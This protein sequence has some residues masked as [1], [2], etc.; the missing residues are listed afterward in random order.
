MRRVLLVVAA[1]AVGCSPAPTCSEGD[2]QCADAGAGGAAGGGSA[3]GSGGAGGMAGGTAGGM[4]GGGGTTDS[5]VTDAGSVVAMPASLSFADTGIGQSSAPLT[6]MLRNDTTLSVSFQGAQVLADAGFSVSSDGCNTSTV[7]PQ[8]AC[9]VQVVAR[10][11]VEGPSTDSLQVSVQGRPAVVVPLS[12]TGYPV[13]RLT[14]TIAGTARDAGFV[15]AADGGFSCRGGPCELVAR[16]GSTVVLEAAVPDLSL[17]FVGFDG[18]GCGTSATCQVSMS[19]DAS[20]IQADFDFY[21]RIF[22]SA[23]LRN[24]AIRDAGTCDEELAARPGHTWHFAVTPDINEAPLTSSRGWVRIDGVPFADRHSSIVDP[25]VP[26]TNYTAILYSADGGRMPEQALWAGIGVAPVNCLDFTSSSSL[27][28]SAMAFAGRERWLDFS[29]YPC[30]QLAGVACIESGGRAPLPPRPI[31]AGGRRAFRSRATGDGA[32]SNA[33]ADQ[34]CNDEATAPAGTFV[35]LRDEADGGPAINRVRLDA[36]TWYRPD[37]IPLLFSP[38]DL[39][40]VSTVD[41]KLLANLGQ[42]SDGGIVTSGAVWTG[43]I[44]NCSGWTSTSGSA[45]VGGTTQS[46]SY[47]VFAAAIGDCS[48]PRAVYCFER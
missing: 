16:R 13:S 18:G 22:V 39:A 34:A 26:T 12:V 42:F 7:A 36:G 6:V 10:P 23:R 24:G 11:T 1:V 41:T 28:D 32:W 31:P 27:D 4:A 3:G 5:G 48:Q 35:A 45:G 25:Y 19:A 33:A 47:R 9:A 43:G 15:V 44:A 38:S 8:G 46:V 14:V 37:G 2:A 29:S 40:T 20:V 21:N 17:G 30:N